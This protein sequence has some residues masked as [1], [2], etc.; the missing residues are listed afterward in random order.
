MKNRG[1][2]FD[3]WEIE[4][5]KDKTEGIPRSSWP[6]L[7]SP[8]VL[9]LCSPPRV[10]WFQFPASPPVYVSFS[11]KTMTE[12]PRESMYCLTRTTERASSSSSTHFTLLS[13]G[14]LDDEKIKS[15]WRIERVFPAIAKTQRGAEGGGRRNG[16]G[17][18]VHT[19]GN[20][21][22]IVGF[23]LS[24]LSS[25][26]KLENFVYKNN[27]IMSARAESD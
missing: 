24:L 9:L 21:N 20:R 17:F 19:W 1:Q 14:A 5:I 15:P 13:P 26:A 22:Y 7:L 8:S 27:K 3:E 25:S 4:G 6:L 18:W 11:R 16:F 2:M 23:S 12:I 10:C